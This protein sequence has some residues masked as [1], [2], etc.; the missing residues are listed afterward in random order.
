[1][2]ELT[3]LV[4][5]AV[6]AVCDVDASVVACPHEHAKSSVA[7]YTGLIY[8]HDVRGVL[9]AAV[10]RCRREVALVHLH[11]VWGL[12]VCNLINGILEML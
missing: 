6:Q 11:V 5:M 10:V 9:L 8:V 2:R 4:Q 12:V 7:G 1:M 3:E